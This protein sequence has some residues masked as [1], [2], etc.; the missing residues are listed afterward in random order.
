M[1]VYAHRGYSGKYPENTMTAFK[2]AVETGCDGI[3]LDVQLSR[4]GV[5][6]VIHDETVDRTTNGR[7]FVRNLTCK[8]LKNLD[9]SKVRRKK[10]SFMQI[11][12]FD[13]YCQWVKDTGL[14]T[15]IE[16]K[17]S[18]YYY[19]GLEEKTVNI[20]KKYGLEKN[21]MFSSFNHLSLIR[22][23]QLAPQIPCGALVS[24]GGI[25]N[26]GYYCSSF[27]FEYYHPDFSG[28]TKKVADD[29]RTKGISLNVWTI[30]EIGALEQLYDWGCEGVITNYPDDCKRW[31]EARKYIM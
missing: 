11:P 14:F 6:M 17:T 13:E 20:V 18:V 1:K 31:L 26:A 3:E 10:F 27:G 28:L 22:V 8:E 7:G 4:D 19:K 30:N 2:K 25:G 12:T 9:A 5:V 24:K 21:V 16:L 29:C 15:N 23:K